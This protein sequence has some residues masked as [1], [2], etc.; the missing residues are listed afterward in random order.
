MAIEAPL[1]SPKSPLPGSEYSVEIKTLSSVV[2]SPDERAEFF[3]CDDRNERKKLDADFPGSTFEP[4]L[5]EYGKAAW[6]LVF[7]LLTGPVHT[8]Q[9]F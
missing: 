5:N 9:R 8:L 3:L 2:I 4:T 1:D 6:N 7:F